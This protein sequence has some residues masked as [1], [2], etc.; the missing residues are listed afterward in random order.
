MFAETEGNR[1]SV[2]RVM[3]YTND[4]EQEEPEFLVEDKLLAA[5]EAAAAA[6]AAAM[7]AAGNLT[8][9]SAPGAGAIVRGAGAAADAIAANAVAGWRGAANGGYRDDVTVVV[10]PLV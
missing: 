6:A 2:E 8:L 1:A 9:R 5:S 10:A 3:T 4:I 7:G